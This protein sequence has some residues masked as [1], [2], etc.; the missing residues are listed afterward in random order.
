MDEVIAPHK[1]AVSGHPTVPVSQSIRASA[2][3]H[4]RD[5]AELLNVDVHHLAAVRGFHTTHDAT[6]GVVERAQLGAM[7]QRVSTRCTVEG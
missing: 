1:L 2:S 5:L 4:R 6:G 7:P 3:G